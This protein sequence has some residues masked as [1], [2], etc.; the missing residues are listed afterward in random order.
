MSPPYILGISGLYHDSAAAIVRGADILAAA[1]EERFTRKKH[2]RRFPGNAVNYCL[3]EAF[4]EPGDLELV[5]YY[6]NPWLTLDRVLRN[7][8]AV[9]PRG[10]DPLRGAAPRPV[11]RRRL[12]AGAGRALVAG[13][14]APADGPS[15]T[16]S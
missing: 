7:F 3:G 4:I 8:A 10:R 11:R 12:P 9:A 14:P 2:D 6:D 13:P 16:R 15:P 5:A 1:Q